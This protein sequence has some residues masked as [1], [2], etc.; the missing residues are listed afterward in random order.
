MPASAAT[1]DQTSD[2]GNGS[3][4]DGIQCDD[5]DQH[6]REHHHG[7][8]ALAVAVGPCIDKSGDAH[9]KC[10]GEED[11]AWLR[12]PQSLPEPSPVASDSRHA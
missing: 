6:E 8:A 9:E 7:C 3:S 2:K 4:A 1:T 10:N 5:A 11:P 12:E